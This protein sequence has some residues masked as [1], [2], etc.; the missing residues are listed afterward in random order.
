MLTAAATPYLHG[1]VCLS[2]C[3]RACF[4]EPRNGAKERRLVLLRR[5]GSTI[6]RRA[7]EAG[8]MT[9]SLTHSL[10]VLSAAERAPAR[11]A[12]SIQ[13]QAEGRRMAAQRFATARMPRCM[14]RSLRAGQ[15]TCVVVVVIVVIVVVVV[16]LVLVL[17]LDVVLVGATSSHTRQ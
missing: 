4:R 2:A 1:S 5:T 13:R 14:Q 6:C 12:T 7:N 8:N 3:V 16:V 10:T 17:V 9:R 11:T 15:R